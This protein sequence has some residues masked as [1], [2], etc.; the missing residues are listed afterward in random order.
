M[1][2]F[3]FKSTFIGEGPDIIRDLNPENTMKL[4][5]QSDPA[6]ILFYDPQTHII[7]QMELDLVYDEIS[8]KILVIKADITAIITRNLASLLNIDIE[9]MQTA[10]LKIV[11]PGA[12]R[13]KVL[14]YSPKPDFP[15]KF[16][17]ADIN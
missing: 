4:F 2:A 16:L 12:G 8:N 6:L 10:Q 9:S 14:K 7:P 3:F 13:Q 17:A 11:V 1:E 5:S 15:T